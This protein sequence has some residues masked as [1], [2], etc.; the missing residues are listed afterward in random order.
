MV[1]KFIRNIEEPQE[2]ELSD[3]EGE[4]VQQEQDD[5]KF[6]NEEEALENHCQKIKNDFQKLMK[7]K[8]IPWIE[9]MDLVSDS[10]VDSNLNIDDDI[11]REVI[12]YNLTLQNAVR[13]I[14]KLKEQGEKLN[15]PGDFFAEMVKS[16]NQMGR[17][18][19]QIITEQQ[20]IKKFEE[21]KNKIQNIKFAKAMK[22]SQQKQKSDY[23]KKT[24][25]A[26]EGWKKRIIYIKF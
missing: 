16:D 10:T 20:R 6:V 18:K 7:N 4:F 12:F 13:G 24:K 25:E 17:I 23:K 19:K 26:I 2:E 11:K 14:I 1:K 8:D 22:D 5:I 9:T 3:L 21:K 15:R